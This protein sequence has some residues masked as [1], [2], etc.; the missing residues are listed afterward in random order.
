VK[1]WRWANLALGL[2]AVLILVAGALYI[3]PSDEYILLP[4]AARPLA[5]LVKVQG[6]KPDANG[7]G[8]YYVAVDVRKASVLEQKV[9]GLHD[10]AT[11]V[12]ADQI[13]P[14]GENDRQRRRGELRQMA[15]SQ[16]YAAAVAL[17]ELGYKVPIRTR[18]VLIEGVDPDFPAA[19]KLEPDDVIV[20]IDGEKVTN[21]AELTQ[22]M[23]EKKPGDT[24]RLKVRRG[25]ETVD[26]AVKTVANPRDKSRPFLGV[27]ISDDAEIVKLPVNVKI[28][29][30]NVGGPS[31]GLAF[32][33]D[34][35]D[36]L[37]KDVDRGRRVAATGE[38]ALDGSVLPVGGIKQK[39]IGA[40]RSHAD[41]FLVPGENAAEARRYADGLRIIPVDSFQQ[42]LRKL[43]TLPTNA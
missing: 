11:F 12:P 36:E 9:P 23:S 35:V 1:R 8:I 39:T 15:R 22:V 25:D 10:G 41:V 33:L 42:A 2:G 34:V 31:A 3:I 29:L 24:V 18:G 40:R 14:E 38:I 37:G 21:T 17:R 28:N 32:A 16:Q 19:G 5:P 27:A 20:A 6:E 4:A 13:N 26:V 30:G 7:G 43:A